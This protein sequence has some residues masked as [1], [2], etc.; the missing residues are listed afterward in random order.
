[1]VTL[2]T[3]KF[4]LPWPAR[5]VIPIYIFAPLITMVYWKESGIT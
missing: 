2:S 5:P 4:F 1:M 3:K